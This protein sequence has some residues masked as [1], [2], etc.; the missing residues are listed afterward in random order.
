VAC[1]EFKICRA[2]PT[3]AKWTTHR[4]PRPVDEEQAGLPLFDTARI[5]AVAALEY[6]L[7]AAR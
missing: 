7:M 6:A 1:D 2:Y 5:H 3:L 4:H